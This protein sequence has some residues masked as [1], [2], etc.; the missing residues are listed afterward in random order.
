[1]K[2]NQFVQL[3]EKRWQQFEALSVNSAG[4]EDMPAEFA[5]LYRQVCNDLAT[6]RTRHYSP[7]LIA[8]LNEFVSTGQSILYQGEGIKIGSLLRLFKQNFFRS[9]FENRYYLWLSVGAFYGLALLAYFW[10]RFDPDAVYYFLD[11]ESIK[12]IE[13][14]YDPAGSVQTKERSSGSTVLMFGV[15]IYNNIGIAF[16]M[17]GGGALFG[18]GAILPL[19]FNSFY[20][21]AISAHIVNIGYESTFFSF[22][23]THGSF[24]LTAIAIAGAAGAKIGFSLLMPKQYSR[25]HAIKTAGSSVLPLIVGAFIM[26]FIAAI[27]EAFWSPL[28]IPNTFKYSAGALCWFYVLLM[29]YRGTRYGHN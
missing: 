7:A 29:F 10:V 2:Q 4:E 25:A 23:V 26:L 6:A 8:K 28:N 13:K 19:L 21:G 12:D 1:M 24:E 17:F 3:N 14:M 9:L 16:Q 22:V 20:F 15:Y 27:I 18:I 5:V 11:V